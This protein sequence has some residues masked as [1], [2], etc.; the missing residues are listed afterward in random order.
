[1]AITPKIV[2][3]QK[4]LKRTNIWNETKDKNGKRA[5]LRMTNIIL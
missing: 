4:N 3:T 2:L 5:R 1:M